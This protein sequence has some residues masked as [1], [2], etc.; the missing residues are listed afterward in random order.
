MQHLETT[1]THLV[2]ANR[3][4]KLVA[5]SLSPTRPLIESDLTECLSGG[6]PVFLVGD[7]NAKHGL[8]S[9]ADHSQGFAPA[10]LRQQKHLLDLWAGLHN[11]SSLHTQCYTRRLWLSRTS[12]YRCI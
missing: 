5:A 8:E 4:V 3:P 10:S 11:H 1:A 2:L 7:L 9:L 12:Y 6:F